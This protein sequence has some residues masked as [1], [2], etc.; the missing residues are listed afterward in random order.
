MPSSKPARRRG[1]PVTFARGGTSGSGSC[2]Q[3]RRQL[4]RRAGLD[5]EVVDALAAVRA[6]SVRRSS[7]PT[8][9]SKFGRSV[10]RAPPRAT[11]PGRASAARV[12][13][14]TVPSGMP[15]N[16]A[17]SD[18]ESPLQYA[19]SITLRSFVVQLLERAVDAPGGPARLG[20]LGRAGVRGGLVGRLGRRLGAGSAAVDDRVARDG[21]EPRRA[22][23][24][25]GPVAAG[26][27]PDRGEGLLHRVLGAAAVAEPAQREPE[28]R[29]RVAPVE[30]VERAAVAVGGAADQL[31]VAEVVGRH[32]RDGG[33]FRPAR[34]AHGVERELHRIAFYASGAAPD[35]SSRPPSTTSVVPVTKL[36][37]AR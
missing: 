8:S 6:S 11:R 22:G 29:S 16:S 5:Q 23:P 20:A 35:L 21:V 25:L 13:V 34:Q 14:L 2:E 15:R 31:A 4:G 3:V 19:S 27:A 30:D 33:W 10:I 9:S 12:R 24:A 28:H 7:P 32:R 1:R 36:A 18:C 37:P 17:I 26:G